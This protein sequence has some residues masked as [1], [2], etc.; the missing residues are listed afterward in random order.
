MKVWHI[1]CY[2]KLEILSVTDNLRTPYGVS[3]QWDIIQ[4]G[5]CKM[6]KRFLKK[7]GPLLLLPMLAFITAHKFYVS[8]TQ[9]DY[10]EKEA[11]LQVTS[12]IFIDDMELLL[13]E[14]YGIVAGLATAD[15]SQ[16]VD[17]YLEKY[18]RS[19][20]VLRVN[21]QEAAFTFLGKRFDNDIL[22]CYMEI[23]EVPLAT[24]SSLE[25]QNE[26]LTELFE[27]QKNIVHM[28]I[29]DQKRSFVLF[30]ENNKGMLNL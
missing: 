13:K 27:D 16:A 25:V 24:L 19:K 22:V 30:R 2:R 26:L 8:V 6:M 7:I 14:R 11:A 4:D 12:R 28:R 10:S 5:M 17:E 20:F 21:G 23:P 3:F 1:Y 18:L 15:E 29:G 9:I